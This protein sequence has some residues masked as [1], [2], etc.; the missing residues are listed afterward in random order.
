MKKSTRVLLAIVAV[1][2]LFAA[3]CGSDSVTG[4]L[5]DAAGDAAE[6]AAD[7][8]GDAADA[9]GDAVEDAADAAGDAMDDAMDDEGA[10]HSDDAMEDDAMEDDAMEDDASLVPP[11]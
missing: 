11:T 5:V 1:L 7:A 6:G 2:S 3:A 9:A 4:D 10:D 8:A